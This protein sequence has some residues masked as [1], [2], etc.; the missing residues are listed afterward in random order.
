MIALRVAAVALSS[1]AVA[2]QAPDL[3]DGPGKAVL[4]T[5]CSQCHGVEV[6][7]SQPRSRDEWTEVVSRMVGAGA[8]LTDEDYGLVVEY[9]AAHFG[10]SAQTAPAADRKAS[11][12]HGAIR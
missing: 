12:G 3:P 8:Q 4:Q 2:A 7:T 11:P 5:A 1:L 10:P 9:L 6:V